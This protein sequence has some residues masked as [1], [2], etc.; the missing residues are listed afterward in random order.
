MARS[1]DT[2]PLVIAPGET[3]V[4]L[5]DFDVDE[6]FVIQGDPETPAGIYGALFTPTI[7][8]TA[9]TGAPAS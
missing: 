7:S 1:D 2:G 4:L 6:S 3:L 8:V 9:S 5:V